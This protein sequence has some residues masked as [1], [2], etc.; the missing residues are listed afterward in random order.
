MLCKF[1]LD[2]RILKYFQKFKRT[3]FN[4]RK[5]LF[6][7]KFQQ[8]LGLICNKAA[9]VMITSTFARKPFT[10]LNLLPKLKTFAKGDLSFF[11]NYKNTLNFALKIFNYQTR[12]NTKFTHYPK[13]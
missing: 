1:S 4:K 8:S 12:R 7:S 9:K 6:D 11:H 3:L 13:F 5:T 2:Q 10:K